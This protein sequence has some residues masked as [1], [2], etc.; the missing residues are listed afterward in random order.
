MHIKTQINKDGFTNS[1]NP[2]C[3]KYQ[4]NNLLSPFFFKFFIYLFKKKIVK[5]KT[6]NMKLLLMQTVK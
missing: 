1:C 5:P 2:E 4:G 3:V 6:I